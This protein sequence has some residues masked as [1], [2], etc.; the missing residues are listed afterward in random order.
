MTR[1]LIATWLMRLTDTLRGS[2]AM[3]LF[4]AFGI[5]KV[6][7]L[8]HM[9]H[10]KEYVRLLGALKK[11]FILL[12]LISSHSRISP[13]NCCANQQAVWKVS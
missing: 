7:L 11:Y 8:S 9:V 3:T 5:D 12:L 2:G 10:R 1:W 4:N 6:S 13:Q